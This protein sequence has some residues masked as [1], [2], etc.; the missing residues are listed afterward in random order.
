MKFHCMKK[1]LFLIGL[2]FF[3]SSCEKKTI[4]TLILGDSSN[5]NIIISPENKTLNNGFGFGRDSLAL[6][7]NKDNTSD[8]FHRIQCS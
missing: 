4:S 6:D 3:F 1:T 7:L 8:I 5:S 2:T